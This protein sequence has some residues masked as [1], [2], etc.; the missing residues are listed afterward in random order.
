MRANRI[1]HE[2]RGSIRGMRLA[3]GI[4]AI[5][6]LVILGVFV[7]QSVAVRQLYW[8]LSGMIGRSS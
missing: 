3:S 5:L 4:A 1:G 8:M 2:S 7:H 6:A